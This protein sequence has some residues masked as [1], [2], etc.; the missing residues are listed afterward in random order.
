MDE[1]FGALDA[2]TRHLMQAELL[3]SGGARPRP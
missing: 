2:Q 1:P 3:G